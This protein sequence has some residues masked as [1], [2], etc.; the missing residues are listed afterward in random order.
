MSVKRKPQDE[1]WWP[2]PYHQGFD[3]LKD[4]G[5]EIERVTKINSLVSISFE[6]NLINEDEWLEARK[7]VSALMLKECVAVSREIRSGV[8]VLRGTRISISQ[9]FAE[10]ADSQ[11]VIELSDE[12]D[13]DFESIKKLLDGLAIHFDRPFL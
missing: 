8:P 13:I 6:P 7:I 12:Y 9:I 11:C 2:V 10:L 3:L 5:I 4:R 1:G